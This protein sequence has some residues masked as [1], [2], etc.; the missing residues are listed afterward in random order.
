[1]PSY[2]FESESDSEADGATK[3]HTRAPELSDDDDGPGPDDTFLFRHSFSKRPRPH[4]PA[5]PPTAGDDDDDL[6]E[7]SFQTDQGD[8]YEDS[9]FQEMQQDDSY[10]EEEE[11]DDGEGGSFY[12]D[13]GFEDEDEE[14]EYSGDPLAATMRIEK[15]ATWLEQIDYTD[16]AVKRL[17]AIDAREKLLSTKIHW[18]G[19]TPEVKYS[20]ED[21]ERDLF[22]KTAK[23]QT[24][25]IRLCLIVDAQEEYV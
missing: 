20:T 1:M 6:G 15:R 22:G 4:A 21:L 19:R 11:M 3:Q 8:Q 9:S 13:E 23:V 25:V 24:P 5:Y 18:G 17:N 7:P 16:L 12:S 2:K 14:P 10:Y